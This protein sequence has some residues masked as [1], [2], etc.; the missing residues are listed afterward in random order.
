MERF[1]SIV[2]PTLNEE[3]YLPRLLY[4]LSRQTFKD[5]EV[6]VVDGGSS[7]ATVEVA[8]TCVDKV[9]VSKCN[10][11]EA[12]NMGVRVSSGDYLV[13]LDADAYVE[14]SF[15]E[16]VCRLISLYAPAKERV[17]L[18]GRPEPLQV[19]VLSRVAFAFGWFLAKL[20]AT[21]PGYM[22]IIVEKSIFKRVGGFNP[23]LSY[24]EDLDLL[25]R[26]SR[27]TRIVYPKDLV[28]YSDTRRWMKDG[29]INAVETLRIVG[30]VI[31]FLATKKSHTSYP[32]IR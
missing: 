8:A 2:I 12:R 10:Q 25:M 4:S 5:F 29:K 26:I 17:C 11:S 24:G 31:E 23:N 19:R 20:K 27:T 1:F 22:G 14:H 7:D 28:V 6:I 13:F 32:V 21:F 16:K 9:L 18:V 30:M 3:K 15:L